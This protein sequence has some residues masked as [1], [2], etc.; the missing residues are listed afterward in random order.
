MRSSRPRREAA[1]A[2]ASAGTAAAAAA[3]TAAACCCC[4]RH[5]PDAARRQVGPDRSRP[6]GAAEALSRSC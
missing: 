3:A 1:A 4:H 5:A 6:G 2:A